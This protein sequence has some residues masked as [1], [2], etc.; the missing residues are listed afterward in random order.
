MRNSFCCILGWHRQAR[1]RIRLG[2]VPPPSRRSPCPTSLSVH[3]PGLSHHAQVPR[4]TIGA[5]GLIVLLG[6][7]FDFTKWARA[8]V[9]RQFRPRIG[10]SLT[11]KCR[12][13]C[14]RD[15]NKLRARGFEIICG[16]VPGFVPNA[17]AKSRGGIRRQNG[18]DRQANCILPSRF[19]NFKTIRVSKPRRRV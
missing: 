2:G 6:C 11:R 18:Q 1:V 10:S 4:P 8:R 17:H 16:F 3:A 14:P 15:K 19:R 9:N 5:R 12:C 7:D 13:F